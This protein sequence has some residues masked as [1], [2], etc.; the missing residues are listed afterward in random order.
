MHGLRSAAVKNR[1]TARTAWSLASALLLAGCFHFSKP[2]PEIHEYRL[3]Y[4]SPPSVSGQ[5]LPVIIRVPSLGVAAVYDRDAIVHRADSYATVADFYNRW[6]ANPG[7]MLA[8]LLA[9]DLDASGLYAAVQ[10]SPS[11]V[12][13]DY[14]LT[15]QVEEIEEREAPEGCHAHLRLR[16]NLLRVRAGNRDPVLLRDT[17]ADEE[18]C[19][20]NDGRAF[21][22]AM[23]RVVQRISAKLQ[24]AVYDAIRKD[25]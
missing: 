1:W 22:E 16:M 11:L 4:A 2:A 10:R 15:G 18:P 21:A 13:N 24:P 19:G 20:C 9:R 14:Q 7:V 6:G 12:P 3:D 25:R 23:S 8:D 17:Y 5:P